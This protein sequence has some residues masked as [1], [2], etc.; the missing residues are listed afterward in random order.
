[1]KAGSEGLGAI[2]RES[3]RSSP[4]DGRLHGAGLVDDGSTWIGEIHS[5]ARLDRTDPGTGGVGTNSIAFP[6]AV[7]PVH[8]VHLG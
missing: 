6:V 7:K 5:G 4:N 2:P 3:P 1:M 8:P